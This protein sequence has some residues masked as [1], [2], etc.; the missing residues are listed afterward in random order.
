MGHLFVGGS[1]SDVKSV[2]EILVN[3]KVSLR[4]MSNITLAFLKLRA[5]NDVMESAMK[6]LMELGLYPTTIDPSMIINPSMMRIMAHFRKAIALKELGDPM[7]SHREFQS[8]IFYSQA[9]ST[10][11]DLKR[12]LLVEQE[13]LYGWKVDDEWLELE[14]AKIGFI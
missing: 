5:W 13:K 8:A 2:S 4:L 3:G 12:Y 11:H 6:C 7:G 1:D 14:R 9:I 10:Q